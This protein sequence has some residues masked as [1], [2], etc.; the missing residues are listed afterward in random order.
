MENQN[1]IKQDYLRRLGHKLSSLPEHERQDALEYYEGYLNDAED[2][3]Q[4]IQ[5]L[6][7]PGEVAADILAD[8][9]TRATI[10]Q[11]HSLKERGRSAKVAWAFIIGIFALPIGLPLIIGGAAVAFGLF[12]AL[13]ATIF[14]IL[15]AGVAA[16]ATGVI[17]LLASPF[18]LVHSVSGG[19]F[20]LGQGLLAL[21]FGILAFK[22]GGMLF[23]GFAVIGR[24]LS[25][26]ILKRRH[27]SHV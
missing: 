11:N 10:R 18:I 21:G 19:I 27:R 16:V 15:V 8:Y 6:G 26:S 1:Q 12:V 23:H 22:L 3:H 7:T 13:G 2:P 17:G 25:Q 9:M 20:A 14:G 4:A 24:K 5:S